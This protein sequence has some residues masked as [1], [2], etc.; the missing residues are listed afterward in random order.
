M[1]VLKGE[2]AHPNHFSF[3][4]LLVLVLAMVNFMQSDLAV[5]LA[6]KGSISGFAVNEAG[7]P[8]QVEVLVFGTAINVLSDENGF[9][10]IENVPAGE[11]SVI[12]AYG[13]IATEVDTAVEPGVENILGTVTIPTDLLIFVDE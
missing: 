4:G 6:R 9:F 11:Q 10:I 12:I 7:T 8:I 1:G 5:V 3:F 13:N 2:K